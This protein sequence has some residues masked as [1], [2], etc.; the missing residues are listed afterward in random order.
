VAGGQWCSLYSCQPWALEDEQQLAHRL[1]Y[2]DHRGR[3]LFPCLERPTEALALIEPQCSLFPPLFII[4]CVKLM[5]VVAS[6]T[7]RISLVKW[8]SRCAFALRAG[9]RLYSIL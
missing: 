8:F 9:R 5:C 1:R 3:L 2:P 4:C 6:L 7:W